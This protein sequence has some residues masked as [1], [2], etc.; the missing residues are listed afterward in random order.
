MILNRNLVY[1]M[2]V[3]DALRSAEVGDNNVTVPPLVM[4]IVAA[5]RQT[6]VIPFA[7]R[8]TLLEGSG[9]TEST[10]LQTNGP[11]LIQTMM[12]LGPGVWELEF[13]M[14]TVFNYTK[15]AADLNGASVT[16]TYQ[17]NVLSLIK[18]FA[19]LN[20]SSVDSAK[21]RFLF[22]SVAVLNQVIPVT[23][24]GQTCESNCSMNAIRIL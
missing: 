3:G 12:T 10:L 19:I 7:L 22:T 5:L 4:P 23:G 9:F 17:G 1:D 6:S 13:N 15:V 2:T 21:F 8:F 16:L 18:R 24:V 14:S 20:L 11:G